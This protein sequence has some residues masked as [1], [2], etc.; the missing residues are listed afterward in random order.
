M[1]TIVSSVGLKGIEGYEVQVEVQLLL[2][3]KGSR[4][5]G[6]RMRQPNVSETSFKVT[7]IHPSRTVNI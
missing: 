4:W 7:G 3:L 1:A 5:L 2:V 6:C